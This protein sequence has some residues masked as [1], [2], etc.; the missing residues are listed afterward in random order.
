MIT[1]CKRLM[2]LA[3]IATLAMSATLAVAQTTTAPATAPTPA[4]KPYVPDPIFAEINGEKIPRDLFTNI[5]IEVSGMRLFNQL[6]ELVVVQQACEGAGI[7]INKEMVLAEKDRILSNLKKQGVPDDQLEAAFQQVLARQGASPREIDWMLNKA[8]GLR[9]LSKGKTGPISDEMLTDAF[10]VQ[11][12]ESYQGRVFIFE[13]M[14]DGL[15]VK[16]AA[17]KEKKPFAEVAQARNIQ[18][19]NIRIPASDAVEFNPKKFKDTI[20]QLSEGEASSVL[21]FENRSVVLVLDKKIAKND[22][23]KFAEVKDKLKAQLTE[24]AE[25][26]WGQQHLQNLIRDAKVDIKDP[27]IRAQREMM[28][29]QYQSAATRAAAA[30]APATAPA[31]E[32][33]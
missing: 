15:D 24:E 23:V 26:R 28:M 5:L 19:Q 27:I 25:M 29:K 2:T 32:K 11:Y 20:K 33:K 30:T 21:D 12:G 8:A 7:K 6:G 10:E 22:K 14:K 1:S 4:P 16:S 31:A 17:M 3:T 13:T 18:A 9:A